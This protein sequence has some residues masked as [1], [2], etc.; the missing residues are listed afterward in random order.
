MAEAT[1]DNAPKKNRARRFRFPRNLGDPK[2][3]HPRQFRQVYLDRTVRRRLLSDRRGVPV[4]I[5]LAAG[6]EMCGF[7]D[8]FG[9]VADFHLPNRS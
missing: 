5:N 6:A 7:G 8:Y 3:V 1:N 2:S 9:R 4:M